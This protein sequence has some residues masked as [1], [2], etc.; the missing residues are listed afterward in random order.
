MEIREK[1]RED[2]FTFE[3][4]RTIETDNEK[5]N[6]VRNFMSNIMKNNKEDT[7]Y[8]QTTLGFLITGE[9]DRKLRNCIGKR[10]RNGKTTIFELM[11]HIFSDNLVSS[12]DK[13]ILIK[14]KSAV[15]EKIHGEHLAVLVGKRLAYF[16]E[17][18]EGDILNIPLI[19]N[20]SGG[21]EIKYRKNYSE[22]KGFKYT[23]H[24]VI[25]T[26][27]QINFDIT[28][29]GTI[30]RI[31]Y[32]LFDQR[33][34]EKEDYKEGVNVLADPKLCQQME[35]KYADAFFTYI[36]EGALRYYKEGLIPTE[37]I[38]EN[39]K[40]Q[41]QELDSLQCFINDKLTEQEKSEEQNEISTAIL[42]TEYKKYCLE[43][44]LLDV[45][46]IQKKFTEEI[47]KTTLKYFI[48][49]HVTYIVG[50]ILH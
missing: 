38:K 12:I 13:S 5:M 45:Y 33:F 19:K 40:Q 43:S 21:D 9:N 44:K 17:T 46:K 6:I 35:T 23:G 16:S 20:L 34:V 11:K 25:F 37:N 24:L 4:N 7:E 47:K 2:I 31:D 29:K 18:D 1:T 30:D 14:P 10:A 8:L 27:K 15:N 36:M 32:L 41:L 22:E 42:Y 48:K 50:Y 26:N 28:D 3:L 49:Y 39:K